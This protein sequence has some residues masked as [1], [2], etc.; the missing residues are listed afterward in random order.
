MV[1]NDVTWLHGAVAHAV[2]GLVTSSISAALYFCFIDA[3][4]SSYRHVPGGFGTKQPPLHSAVED[5]VRGCPSS[6]SGVVFCDF[7]LCVCTC[8]VVVVRLHPVTHTVAGLVTTVF[9]F[10]PRIAD[11][12]HSKDWYWVHRMLGWWQGQEE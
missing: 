3:S 4:A 6:V 8:S 5:A 11:E 12:E 7:S 10:Q 2:T 1:I 9:T